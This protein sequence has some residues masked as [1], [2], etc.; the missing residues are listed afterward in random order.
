LPGI[1][2]L[3]K[4]R[5]IIQQGFDKHS[6]TNPVKLRVV[7]PFW[8][9]LRCQQST[10]FENVHLSKYIKLIPIAGIIL[11][12][13]FFIIAAFIYPGG[14]YL[15]KT[16]TGFSMLH[17]YWCDLLNPLT[18]NDKPNPSTPYAITA[19]IILCSSLIVFWYY[20]P[21]AF[22]TTRF[23]KL[24][25]QVAGT[26]GMLTG[27]LIF[28]RFHSEAITFAGLFGGIAFI[29]TFMGLYKTRW[30]KLFWMGIVCLLLGII[31]FTIYKT[32]FAIIILPMIQK[33]TLGLCLTWIIAIDIKM[34]KQI[35]NAKVKM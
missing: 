20:A 12:I 28:T 26:I 2:T 22:D 17:N 15:D 27:M 19:T 18:H 35:E 23:N 29:A 13:L 3:L 9:K 16:T 14:N 1:Y 11:F 5:P 30:Y 25:I 21:M 33:V 34:R 24:T 10:I 6:Q 31:T 4:I 7:V 8:F 32:R